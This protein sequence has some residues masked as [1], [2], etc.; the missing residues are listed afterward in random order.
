MNERTFSD[1]EIQVL[2]ER[3]AQLQGDTQSRTDHGLTFGELEQVAAESGIDPMFLRAALRETDSGV[4]PRNV[5]G[6]T[7]THV[8]VE[9]TVPGT[10]SETEW[11]TVVLKLRERFSSDLAMSFGMG[12]QYGP[13]VVEQ[14]GETQ[15]WRHTTSAGVATTVTIRS[16]EGVQHIRIQRR[17]GLARPMVEGIG[18]GSIVA[19]LAGPIA[20]VMAGSEPVA[21]LVFVL[22]WIVSALGITALDKAWRQRKLDEID[23]VVDEIAQVIHDEAAEAVRAPETAAPRLDLDALPDAPDLSSPDG[24][25]TRTSS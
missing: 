11:E 10:L 1:D 4:G 9:K 12:P 15:T 5:S 17:V 8:F 3:A 25:R 16:T 22:A 24:T 13:G 14:L 20:G 23:E 18:Y 7:K 6:H 21:I 2:L 19:F